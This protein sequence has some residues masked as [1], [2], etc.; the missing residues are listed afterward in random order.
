M[1]T[2]NQD[3]KDEYITLK[4][5]KYATTDIV[6]ELKYPFKFEYF[7]GIGTSIGLKLM[8]LYQNECSEKNKLNKVLV[9]DGTNVKIYIDYV[10]NTILEILNEAYNK[11]VKS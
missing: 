3:I 4:F 10:K 11:L 2:V 1:Y 9:D 7:N 5:L 6:F 8:D